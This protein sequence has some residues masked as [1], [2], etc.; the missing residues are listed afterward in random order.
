MRLS[1]AA[2]VF[3]QRGGLPRFTGAAGPSMCT[4]PILHSKE[5][6]RHCAAPDEEATVVSRIGAFLGRCL[7]YITG[8]NAK[9]L[10]G[11]FCV[12][13]CVLVLV[14][15]GAYVVES[16][17][18][19]QNV[20]GSNG[21]KAVISL[22]GAP[23][24]TDTGKLLLVT[25][26]AVGIPGYPVT[27]AQTLWGWIDPHESVIPREAVFQAGQSAA[28]YRKE[29]EGQMKGSQNSAAGAAL[30]YARTLGVKTTGVKVSM[31]ID[32]IGGPSAGMMYA[33]GVID[34]LTPR[35][36]AGDATIA[37]TGTIDTAGKVGAIGGIRLKMLGARRDGATWFLAPASNCD[38]VV[39]HVPRGLRDVKVSTLRDAYDAIVAIGAGQARSLPHCTA[40]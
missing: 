1:R 37:G 27:N 33:L 20:L 23:S 25:V 29:S 4:M 9:Y 24:H 12:V 11:L 7:H 35:D 16:P 40:R 10:A 6:E 21:G 39:G 22:S 15:P 3:R 30:S 17:G 32:D 34:K 36:E 5:P 14:L 38:E 13:L 31:H 2:A 18:P 28:E 19:T 26:N 8:H